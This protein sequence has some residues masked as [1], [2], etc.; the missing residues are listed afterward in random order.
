MENLLFI[1]LDFTKNRIPNEDLEKWGLFVLEVI[2][3]IVC[4]IIMIHAGY[5]FFQKNKKLKEE[6]KENKK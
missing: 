5:A 6:I 2:A 1:L 4:P 3:V